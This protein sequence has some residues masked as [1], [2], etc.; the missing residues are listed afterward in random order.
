[1]PESINEML[2]LIVI[3]TFPFNFFFRNH[4]DFRAST[5]QFGQLVVNFSN[6]G[7]K[8]FGLLAGVIIFSKT[9][10]MVQQDTQSPRLDTLNSTSDYKLHKTFVNFTMN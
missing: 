9:A 7:V 2:I 8:S 5:K 1:M 4:D 3:L 6:Y 10:S